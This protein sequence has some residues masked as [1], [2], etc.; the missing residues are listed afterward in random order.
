MPDKIDL[1]DV[2]KIALD[3]VMTYDVACRAHRECAGVN[4]EPLDL[5]GSTY[6][7]EETLEEVMREAA[8]AGVMSGSGSGHALFREAVRDVLRDSIP[9]Q[10]IADDPHY[11]AG[12]KFARSRLS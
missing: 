10:D 4:H 5:M 7:F 12:N 9:P 2:G 1:Q 11:L 8:S 6:Y 3:S